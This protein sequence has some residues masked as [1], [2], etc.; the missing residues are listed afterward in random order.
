MPEHKF[1]PRYK[2]FIDERD[3]A[4][5]S[6][7]WKTQI[8][9]SDLLRATFTHMISTCELYYRRATDNEGVD[10]LAARY[11]REDLEQIS[12]RATDEIVQHIQRLRKYVY[13]LAVAGEA[14]ALAR[15]VDKIFV[16]TISQRD[17]LLASNIP[18]RNASLDD[19]VAN[20]FE[21]LMDK[22]LKRFRSNL[23][24]GNS[25]QD[26]MRNLVAQLPEQKRATRPRRSLKT[27]EA[28]RPGQKGKFDAS[29]TYIS[30]EDW[31]EMVDFYKAEYVPQWRGP[32]TVISQAGPKPTAEDYYGWELEQEITDDFVN[33]VRQ[34]QVEAAKANGIQ[35]FIWIAIVDDK[36]DECCLW[37]DGLTT[38][39][40]ESLLKG[41][42]R[43]DECQ[44]TVPPAHFNCRCSL[45]PVTE[46]LPEKTES[47]VGEFEDWLNN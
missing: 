40:I 6:M 18:M 46:A 12:L 33:L 47:A 26:A 22:I 2:K 11:L 34:G 37:R 38:S 5:E 7:L 14:E 29:T 23:L 17:L 36:T 28:D 25:V 15:G 21:N 4:L 19:R 31:E 9:I 3:K 42:R 8:I 39:K 24:M 35:D 44:V 41:E 30:D 13:T 45:A 20:T 32:D 16:T 43:D 27:I 10:L 1:S